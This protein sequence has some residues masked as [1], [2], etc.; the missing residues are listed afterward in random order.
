MDEKKQPQ[1]QQRGWPIERFIAGSI[2]P[3]VLLVLTVLDFA[4]DGD[5]SKYLIGADVLLAF[6]YTG[7]L[8]DLQVW[9]EFTRGE[10]SDK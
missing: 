6:G 8:L 5:V 10:T 7:R 2:G 4:N 9:R 1:P 3:I